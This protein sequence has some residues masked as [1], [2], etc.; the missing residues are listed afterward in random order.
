MACGL[1]THSRPTPSAVPGTRHGLSRLLE[2]EDID[3]LASLG[4]SN[5]QALATALVALPALHKATVG[6]RKKIE[7]ALRDIPPRLESVR[8]MREA[9]SLPLRL[10]MIAAAQSVPAGYL[11]PAGNV[12]VAESLLI[13]AEDDRTRT[14][15]AAALVKGG[16]LLERLSFS[17][18][19]GR[20]VIIGFA[21][22]LLVRS[23]PAA[24][25]SISPCRICWGEEDGERLDPALAEAAAAAA[26]T[27]G[28]KDAAH[29]LA[30][31]LLL[32]DVC[33]CRGSLSSVHEGCLVTH[34][35]LT[36]DQTIGRTLTELKCVTCHH[37]FVGRASFLLSRCAAA[38]RAARASQ[39]EVAAAE[40]AALAEVAVAGAAELSEEAALAAA[41]G[42][43][44]EAT[45]LW[46]SGAFEAA[47]ARFAGL[48]STL[49]EMP[50]IAHPMR[51]L[52]KALLQHSTEHNLGLIL[53]TYQ[54]GQRSL[55]TRRQ[56]RE[57]A[58]PL[59]SAA[60]AG[61]EA[62]VG[63]VRLI[64]R[65]HAPP[66]SAPS[67]RLLVSLLLPPSHPSSS[68]PPGLTPPPP[69]PPLPPLL[70]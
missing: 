50:P 22:M 47:L 11:D 55:E 30:A 6:L 68:P 17:L 69:P 16:A 29:N 52:R 32:H 28:S 70:V 41:E 62:I 57:Q 65:R 56:V 49:R 63:T 44:N 23:P 14:A 20:G 12:S 25:V 42:R 40:A 31:G 18:Q 5:R 61:F 34:L 45:A 60:L 46:R 54:N 19:D 27:H 1:T 53:I 38:V 9:V 64:M 15:H 66:L 51:A 26:I 43:A 4:R 48:V 10:A 59:V 58:Q 33:G 24:A 35:C 13:D 21:D 7:L 2:Y 8:L 36:T 37:P 3:Q 39:D 67:H